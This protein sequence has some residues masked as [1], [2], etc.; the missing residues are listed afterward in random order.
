MIKTLTKYWISF[1]R[2][3]YTVIA[4]A[5]KQSLVL[6]YAAYLKPGIAAPL[7]GSQ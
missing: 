2:K 1:W 6:F 4:N 7:R 3:G 5:V